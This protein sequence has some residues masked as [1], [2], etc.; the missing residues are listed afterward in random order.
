MART[1]DV[2]M[3][4][5]I[6]FT[7][8]KADAD[9]ARERLATEAKEAGKDS[10]SF[11]VRDSGGCC[12]VMETIRISSYCGLT[13]RYKAYNKLA[14]LKAQQG[15]GSMTEFTVTEGRE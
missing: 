2:L 15:P 4:S 10:A 9:A 13:G 6:V 1:W 12:R 7:V 14:E 3:A 5:P 8:T 11:D